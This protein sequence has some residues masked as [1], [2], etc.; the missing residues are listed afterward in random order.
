M[1]R[2]LLLFVAA[3]VLGGAAAVLGSMVGAATGKA[4]L[5]IGGIVGGLVG[6]VA[7]AAVAQRW[8]W[9]R[10]DAT[11]STAVGTAIGFLAAAA[12]ATQ[13]LQS[14]VGPILSTGLI[15]IGALLGSRMRSRA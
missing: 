10:P 1:R 14:P 11:R 8:R 7:T 9:I 4:G 2:R 3:C 13:T 5:F 12:V 6:A 15:G